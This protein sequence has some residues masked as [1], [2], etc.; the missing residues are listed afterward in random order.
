MLK[1]IIFLLLIVIIITPLPNSF[2]ILTEQNNSL[3]TSNSIVDNTII[4]EDDANLL[5]DIEK[6]ELRSYMAALSEYGYVML[7]TTDIAN[8]SSSLRYIKNY[9]YSKLGNKSGVA[10]YIDMDNRQLCACATGGLDRIITNSK[11]DTIM[12]N[13]YTYATRGEYFECAKET[14]TEMN[15]LLS[16]GRIAESMKYYCNAILSI[17]ISLFAS[18]GFFM[19]IAKNKKA[20]QKELINECVVSLEHSSIEVNK[21][22]SHRVYSPVSDSSSSG[23]GS[24]GGGGRRRIF[25]KWWKPWVLVYNIVY[26]DY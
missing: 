19:L 13:V 10:F 25:W 24:S 4:I 11:C 7:K 8:D 21:T 23:G 14:F 3:S 22:G 18:Y 20:S 15:R 2:A 6:Q 5:T 17:M 26:I 9:Y 16:G 1:K 12:D